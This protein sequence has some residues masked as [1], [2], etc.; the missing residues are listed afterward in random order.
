LWRQRN[1]QRNG[2]MG[3]CK[4]QR[5]EIRDFLRKI[6]KKGRET[7]QTEV[8]LVI[9]CTLKRRFK[10]I[11]IIILSFIYIIR[12]ETCQVGQSVLVS[13]THLR[14]I[15]PLLSLIIFRQLP[16]CWLGTPSLTRSRVCGFQCLEMC[17]FFGFHMCI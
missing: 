5:R 13:G 12:E 7:E 9:S 10:L 6:M 14:P 4:L 11:H 8:S 15:F 1:T 2:L 17:V 16:I 3:L